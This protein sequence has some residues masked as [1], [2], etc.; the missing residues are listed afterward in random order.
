M[1]VVEMTETDFS[2]MDGDR[3]AT[4]A[5]GNMGSSSLI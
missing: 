5:G 3:M 1:E 4:E 2:E